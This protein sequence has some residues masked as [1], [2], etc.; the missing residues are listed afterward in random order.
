M[1][2]T[3]N[4]GCTASPGSAVQLITVAGWPD[5]WTMRAAATGPAVAAARIE[6]AQ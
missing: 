4:C 2:S 3:H 6:G 1:P 5:R